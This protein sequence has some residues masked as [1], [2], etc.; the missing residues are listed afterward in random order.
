MKIKLIL[1]SNEDHCVIMHLNN[2]KSY[3]FCCDND[4]VYSF[5][6]VCCEMM[7]YFFYSLL[8]QTMSL[9]FQCVV[10]YGYISSILYYFKQSLS[11]STGDTFF[12]LITTFLNISKGGSKIIESWLIAKVELKTAFTYC[13]LQSLIW[14][15]FEKSCNI[16][17]HVTSA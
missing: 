5:M 4:S 10:R 6:S 11:S 13:V 1:H 3:P 16:P 8:L 12:H 7:I 15:T 9:I 14:H 2:W 17:L